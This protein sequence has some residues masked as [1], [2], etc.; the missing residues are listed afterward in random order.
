MQERYTLRSSLWLG[1]LLGGAL[2]SACSS[3]IK[4]PPEPPMTIRRADD[5]FRFRQ[6]ADAVAL[7]SAYTDVVDKDEYTA[8]ALYKKALAQYQLG[9]YGDV[10]VTLQ[11]MQK[12]YPGGRWVQVEALRGDA[13]RAMGFPVAAIESWDQ[14]W[15]VATSADR[16][17]LRVRIGTVARDL[18]TPQ[19]QE[20]RALVQSKEVGEIIDFQIARREK[21]ELDEPLP[22]WEEPEKDE[23]AVAAV[24]KPAE[25]GSEPPLPPA[26]IQTAAPVTA[27]EA[28]LEPG[29]PAEASDSTPASDVP[30]QA[31]AVP[32]EGPEEQA[33]PAEVA[34]AAARAQQDIDLGDVRIGLLLSGSAAENEQLE[35][36]VAMAVG[37][38]AVLSRLVHSGN[39]QQSV[40]EL[41]RDPQLLA[42]IGP[43]ESETARLAAETASRW[44]LPLLEL[45]S[46]DADARPYVIHAGVMRAD[47]LGPLLD[48]AM[49]QARLKQF[50]VVYPDNASG[51]S[52]YRSFQASVAQR[53]GQVIGADAYAPDARSLT[54]GLVHRWRDKG[55]LQALVLS[56]GS[57]AAGTFAKFL[58]REMP[59]ITLLG[60]NDWDALS[61]EPMR[62][63]GV[64]FASVFAADSPRPATRDFVVQFEQERGRKPSTIDALGFEAGLLIRQALAKGVASRRTLWQELQTVSAFEG[65]TG[66]V[67]IVG[68]RLERR[69]VLL[70]LSRGKLQEIKSAGPVAEIAAAP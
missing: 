41:S 20:A 70:R 7:Y 17:R 54:A 11:E 19:L 44:Q 55:N 61:E 25:H 16:T 49:Q 62:L 12:R 9:R 3:K 30:V 8:R 40:E 39:V 59:D 33:L 45:S 24:P 32:S 37:R 65:P 53:G 27:P 21:P 34:E 52:F 5:A 69:P 2:L 1:I 15:E 14:G 56:D 51:Q 66:D 48:Y 28:T 13:Q 38:S 36:A 60:V 47:L 10:L 58:Q 42:V 67:R 26:E 64:V 4:A 63:S 35:H 50:G 46:G 23:L 31:A 18:D 22:E 57:T 29:R 68:Q 6:Y 43:V